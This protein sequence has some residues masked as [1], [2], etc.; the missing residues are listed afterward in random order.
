MYIVDRDV[1]IDRLSH[2]NKQ[3]INATSSIKQNDTEKRMQA[4]RQNILRKRGLWEAVALSSKGNPDEL[5]DM[6]P[7]VIVDRYIASRL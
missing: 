7:T 2:A 4:A 3:F 5:M 6:K 1:A